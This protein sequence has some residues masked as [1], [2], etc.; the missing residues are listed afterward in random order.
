MS[1]YTWLDP[2][3]T[4]FWEPLPQMYTF[5][6]DAAAARTLIL[7]QALTAAAAIK[8]HRSPA[9]ADPEAQA[10]CVFGARAILSALSDPGVP[11]RTRRAVRMHFADLSAGVATLGVYAAGSPLIV[12]ASQET[13]GGAIDIVQAGVLSRG[14]YR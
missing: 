12:R 11:D 14:E 1:S 7:A 2:R 5:Y 8:L 3:I 4:Q 9:A 6:A 13:F 10:K